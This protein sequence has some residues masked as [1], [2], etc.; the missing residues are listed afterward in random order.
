[1]VQGITGHV[2]FDTTEEWAKFRINYSQIYDVV[3]NTSKVKITSIQVKT[4]SWYGFTYYLDGSIMVNGVTAVSCNSFQGTSNVIMNTQDIWYTCTNASGEV[5]VNHNT[6][7]TAAISI[8]FGAREWS[9]FYFYN[10]KHPFGIPA[11]STASVTLTTIQRASPITSASDVSIGSACNVAWTPYSTSFYY[12]LKF[13]I[14]SWSATTDVIQ[15]DTTSTYI[16]TGYTI[17]NDVANQLPNATSGTMTVALYTF[18][19]ISC[20]EQ[21]GSAS[22]KTF[23]VSVPSTM[24]PTVGSVTATIDNSGNSVVNGWGIAVAGY[25]K[26]NVVATG[27]GSYGSTISNFTITGGYSVIQ[28]GTSLSYTGGEV[29]SSGNQTFTVTCKDSRGRISSEVE[30]NPIAFYSYAKPSVYNFSVARSSNDA[31]KVI[32]NANWSFSPVNGNNS[33]T[34]TLYYKKSSSSGWTM[35][36]AIPINTDVE[37]T[38]SFEEISSYNFKIVVTDALSGTDQAEGFISTLEVLLDFRSGGKGLGIGKI[39][40]SDAMEVALPATFNNLAI[41]NGG[42]RGNLGY[43]V[44]SNGDYVIHD[45]CNEILN[46]D[47]GIGLL[48]AYDVEDCSKYLIATF[49]HCHLTSLNVSILSTNGLSETHNQ[50]GSISLSGGS[51][52]YMFSILPLVGHP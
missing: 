4:T 34:G 43:H 42:I 15:P 28:N 8:T 5:T 16:Y 10:S 40:E 47:G 3:S 14:G 12:K 11:E 37:L 45:A 35:Y 24:K 49:N 33:A 23:I 38:T 46:A 21:I 48:F 30:S 52:A 22:T 29:L 18:S 50:N 7:G 13:S 51:G 2:D 27:I 25:T 39:C 9:I 31:T 6:D 32:A 26:V 17:V 1:M 41:F 20:T 36:G 44:E 19:S